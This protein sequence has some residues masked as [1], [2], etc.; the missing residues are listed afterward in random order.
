[1]DASVA[2]KMKFAKEGVGMVFGLAI[3]FLLGVFILVYTAFPESGG[4]RVMWEYAKTQPLVLTHIILGTLLFLG[5]VSFAVRAYKA[6]GAVW[7]RSTLV[8]LIAIFGAWISGE[9]FV[10]S[11][12]DVYSVSMSVSFILA[13]L[14]YVWGIYRSI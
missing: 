10:S 3:Q 1:M 2:R 7:I 9:E 5:A 12:Q 14:S 4:A 11:Q 13:M 8:G 6:K